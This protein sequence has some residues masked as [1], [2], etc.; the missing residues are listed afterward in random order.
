MTKPSLSD[1]GTYDESTV[2][3]LWDGVIGA[4][5]PSLGPTG[6]RLHDFSRY[7]NWG[8]L[9]NMDPATDWVVDGGQYALDFDGVNDYVDARVTLTG[10]FAVSMWAN[11]R[12][13]G[14]YNSRIMWG[15]LTDPDTYSAAITPTTVITQ[16]DNV[17]TLKTFSGFSFTNS[18]WF[19]IAV[20]RDATNS[21]RVWKDGVESASGTQTVT[22]TYTLQGI[23]R[24][25]NNLGDNSFFQWDGLISDVVVWGKP[26]TPNEVTELYLLGRGGMFQR[27]RLRRA[28]V[29]E[30]VVRS[31]LFVNRGQVIG[32]GTL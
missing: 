19:H 10:A 18:V 6:S 15:N 32:G 16:S 27:R 14:A 1:Y 31:Y 26:L 23:G 8:T 21:V 11:R 30:A 29:S 20:S 3:Q 2:P 17:G 5:C 12:T 13:A 9:T 28:Y 24:Y 22:G 7:N 4:W 25:A